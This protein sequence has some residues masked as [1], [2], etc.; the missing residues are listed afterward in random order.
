MTQLLAQHKTWDALRF[1]KCQ[2]WFA[3][4]L[5]HSRVL[6]R[7]THP[8]IAR[9]YLGVLAARVPVTRVLGSLK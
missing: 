4:Y 1:A 9:N 8:E 3:K 2:A 6:F 7:R 5:L